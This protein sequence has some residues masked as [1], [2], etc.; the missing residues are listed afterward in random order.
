ML[1]DTI[2][3][4]Y[5]PLFLDTVFVFNDSDLEKPMPIFSVS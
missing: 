3:R 2:D 5:Q 1:G 4:P